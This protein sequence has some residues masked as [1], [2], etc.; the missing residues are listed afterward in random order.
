MSLHKAEKENDHSEKRGQI[1]E[2]KGKSND[3]NMT[4]MTLGKGC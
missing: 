3:G 4:T 2:N 1:S